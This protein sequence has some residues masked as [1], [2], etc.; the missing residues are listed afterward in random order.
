MANKTKN[1]NL[2]YG[3][4]TAL[5]VILLILP[6]FIFDFTG[7]SPLK[8]NLGRLFFHMLSFGGA[9]VAGTGL[10]IAFNKLTSASAVTAKA[11]AWAAVG[12]AATGIT[13]NVIQSNVINSSSSL[14]I[15]AV[16]S[17][18]IS[19]RDT[20]LSETTS[21]F[22]TDSQTIE[23]S[24]ELTAENTEPSA[25]DI[26]KP[27]TPKKEVLASNTNN[28]SET[29]KTVKDKIK[30]TDNTTATKDNQPPGANATIEEGCKNFNIIHGTKYLDPKLG[31]SIYDPNKSL[32][33]NND[34][35]CILKD[36]NLVLMRGGKTVEQRKQNG[37]FINLYGFKDLQIDDRLSIE[38]RQAG[39][40][41][42]SGTSISYTFPTPLLK[43][44]V[45]G[46]HRE[47][48]TNNSQSKN[49]KNPKELNTTNDTK[50]PAK[51]KVEEEMNKYG[52]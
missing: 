1:N 52:N 27:G 43:V 34:C 16:D 25:P 51:D 19:T 49:T 2:L 9:I 7:E 24:N 6:F 22:N 45:I 46:D 5:A 23:Q 4:L 3:T 38:I 20:L 50:V 42:K 32:K 17:S 37:N 26:T 13:Y 36:A 11:T 41:D 8:T 40:K 30:K 10:S 35:G 14:K 18:A 47:F 29:K 31:L 21:E 48:E 15:T 39:C 28:S 33:L 12:V 44:I